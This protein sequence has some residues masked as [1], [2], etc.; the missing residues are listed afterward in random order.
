MEGQTSRFL[1]FGDQ[2][3]EGIMGLLQPITEI[4]TVEFQGCQDPPMISLANFEHNLVCKII[5]GGALAR[6]KKR[7]LVHTF[8]DFKRRHANWSRS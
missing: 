2:H 1:Q 5:S 7:S 4:L 8:G 3:I 6:A